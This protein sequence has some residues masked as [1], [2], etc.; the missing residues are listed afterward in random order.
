MIG[1]IS[2]SSFVEI[3][4]GPALIFGFNFPATSKI[5]SGETRQKTKFSSVSG[6]RYWE[7]TV[8]LSG[9]FAASSGP[10]PQKMN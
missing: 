9:I 4:S 2:F 8:S 3:W 5:N 1:M 10:I 6:P 7:N